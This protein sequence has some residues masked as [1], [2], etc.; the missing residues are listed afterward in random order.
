MSNGK[1]E[2]E[3][4]EAIQSLAAE[5][6]SLRDS[7]SNLHSALVIINDQTLT[8]LSRKIDGLDG[9]IRSLKD[10]I[11]KLIQV[12]EYDIKVHLQAKKSS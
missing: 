11:R 8:N 4:L 1:D 5:V 12:L 3:L 2:N 6:T 10:I 9:E 7:T